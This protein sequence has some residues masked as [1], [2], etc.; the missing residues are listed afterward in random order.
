MTEAD[1]AKFL[2]RKCVGSV[3]STKLFYLANEQT[4]ATG[5]LQTVFMYSNDPWNRASFPLEWEFANLAA[6]GVMRDPERGG[7][8]LLSLIWKGVYRS[9][10]PE[11]PLWDGML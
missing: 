1:V 9:K 5:N 8:K 7:E 3:I 2:A 4:A 10:Q 6:V 11:S